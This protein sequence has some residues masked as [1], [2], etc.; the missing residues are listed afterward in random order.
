MPFLPGLLVRREHFV[1]GSGL[2]VTATVWSNKPDVVNNLPGQGHSWYVIQSCCHRLK[3]PTP[4]NQIGLKPY[5]RRCKV[6]N[7]SL[8]VPTPFM[9]SRFVSCNIWATMMMLKSWMEGH[10][11]PSTQISTYL[12][13][14]PTYRFSINSIEQ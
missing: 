8:Y 4:N 6:R 7:G 14:F 3:I 9:D 1:L 11:K 12:K 2:H 10:Y 5:L 13:Y